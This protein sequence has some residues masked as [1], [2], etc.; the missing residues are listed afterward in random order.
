MSALYSACQKY[1]NTLFCNI[2]RFEEF[3]KKSART[4]VKVVGSLYVALNVAYHVDSEGHLN[5]YEV[6]REQ[7]YNSR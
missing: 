4:G 5:V 7:T 1:R 6:E 3:K 2:V